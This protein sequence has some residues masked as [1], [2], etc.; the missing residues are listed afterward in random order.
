L[1]QR[2][3][4]IVNL[5]LCIVRDAMYNAV[6]AGDAAATPSKNFVGKIS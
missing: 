5:L 4:Y 3:L 1:L 2:L 6:G